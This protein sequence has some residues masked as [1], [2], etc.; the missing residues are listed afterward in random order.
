M[1]L[2]RLHWFQVKNRI[3]WVNHPERTFDVLSESGFL[4]FEF[5]LNLAPQAF[6]HLLPKVNFGYVEKF[7]NL[8]MKN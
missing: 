2:Y 5:L 7:I 6:R 4:G 8:V 3:L 1:V